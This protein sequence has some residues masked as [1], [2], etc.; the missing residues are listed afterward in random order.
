MKNAKRLKHI[1]F[2]EEH[3]RQTE[4]LNE[5][6]RTLSDWILPYRILAYVAATSCVLGVLV[7]Y[8]VAATT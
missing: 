7:G 6:N 1:E 2:M 8:I 3:I 5:I 4:I